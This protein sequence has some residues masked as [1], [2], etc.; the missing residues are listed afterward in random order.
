[1]G[2]GTIWEL[3]IHIFNGK[4]QLT[5]FMYISIVYEYQNENFC[6]A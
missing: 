4:R 6:T 2:Y 5:L 1:M 3:Q